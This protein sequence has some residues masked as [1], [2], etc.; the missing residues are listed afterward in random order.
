LRTPFKRGVTLAALGCA[1][2]LAAAPPAPSPDSLYAWY[3]SDAGLQATALGQVTAW[4]NQA[5]T[6]TPALRTL[7]RISGTPQSASFNT[8]GGVRRILRCDGTA[9]VWG[10]SA[11]FGTITSSRAVV[12]YCRLTSTNDGF[13][14]DGSANAPGLT[15]AQVRAG[16]WQVGLQVSGGGSNADTNTLPAAAGVWQTH[17]FEFERLPAA[18]VVRHTMGGGDS[19]IY[20]NR[21]TSG[22]GG[23]ILAKNVA[24]TRGLAVDLAEVLVYDRTL[25]ETERHDLHEYLAAK[26]GS[27][28]EIPPA[29]CTAAQTSRDV[30]SF[31]LHALLDVQVLGPGLVTNLTFNIEGTTDPADIASAAVYFTGARAEFRPL[32]PFGSVAAPLTGTL[33]VVG[34]QELSAGINHFWVAVEPRRGAKWGRVLD[35]TLLSV[36]LADERRTPEVG[37]PP[38]FLTIGNALFST[39]VRRAGDDGV[40][41]YRIPALAATSRGTLLAVFDLRWDNAS[42]LPANVDVG[43]L[44]STD[45]GSTWQWAT[46]TKAIL[47]YDK[48]VPGSSGNGVGDPA[49]LVDRQ[50]GAVWVAA[51]WS[52]GNHGYVGSSAGLG[53]NQTGQYVLTRSDDDGQTWSPPINITA[54]A[55]ANPN[56]GVCFQGPGHGIQ[57]R[58]GTLLFPSQHTDPGGLNARAFFIYS[59][60]HGAS[61]LVSPDVNRTIPP[62]LN[63]NQMVELNSGQIMVSSR[64]PSGG[65][66]KRVWATYTRGATPG[67]GAWS[68]LTYAVPD[69]V[70][71]ASFIRYSSTRDGAS[72]DRLLFANPAS[73]SSRV[74][75]T[76]RMSEDEGKSWTVGRRID[77]RPAAYSDLTILADG[78]VGLLYETGDGNAYETLTF[79]RFDLDWLTQADLDTDGDGMSDYYE[80]INGLDGGRNDAHEDRDGDGI[81]NL[82]EFEAGTM[83]NDAQSVLEIEFVHSGPDGLRLLWATVPGRSYSVLGAVATEG[84]WTIEPGAKDLLAI[85]PHLAWALPAPTIAPRFFR[86]ATPTRR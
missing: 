22:I 17:V 47:D 37:S 55:K 15:R 75:M 46:N 57:L 16:S 54:Q 52:F 44:R 5:T 56:W 26:W 70:C 85:G 1:C 50:T 29:A 74:D 66:G 9:G 23:L 51:L 32:S 18:T 45:N 4:Q 7:D 30:P 40:H 78:T 81:G 83:A 14:F 25:T 53:T 11:N 77:T 80:T 60:N 41:T 42:D 79:V 28:A 33:S 63:E 59:T 84:G 58:D 39:V 64:A 2:A 6:G 43:C 68:A 21:L 65:G 76:V 13:L 35:G 49:V 27:P 82:D 36:G 73:S 71:Q 62:Q 69:P 19:F 31:G 10:A 12:A 34:S 3:Q 48:T 67:D 20:T 38:D 72:R 86:V 61:W 8:A 24:A